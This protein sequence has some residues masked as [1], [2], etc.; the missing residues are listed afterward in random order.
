MCGSSGSNDRC[1]SQAVSYRPPERMLGGGLQYSRLAV[2][3]R[4]ERGNGNQ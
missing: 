4:L 2:C 1:N 3:G